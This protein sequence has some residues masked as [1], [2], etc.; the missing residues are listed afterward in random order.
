M[1]YA[2]EQDLKDRL[3]S[4]LVTLLADEDGDGAGDPTILQ[5]VLDDGAAEIDA[6]LAPRYVTPVSPVLPLLL[7]MNVDLAVYFLFIR[8]R[9]AISAEHLARWKEAR[10]DLDDLARGRSELEGAA[11]RLRGMK[12][13]STTREQEKRFDRDSLE[14]F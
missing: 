11:T 7:R 3:G 9:D 2:Q 12:S 6:S 8:R 4:E 5:A 14:T 10:S 1:A 13:E